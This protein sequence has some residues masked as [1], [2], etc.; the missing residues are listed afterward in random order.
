MRCSGADNW[1]GVGEVAV[2]RQAGLV[3]SPKGWKSTLHLMMRPGYTFI[4]I[5][6][7]SPGST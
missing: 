5:S 3:P 1:H 4:K 6:A 2:D 7:S